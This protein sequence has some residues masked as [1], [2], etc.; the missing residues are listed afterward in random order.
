MA[1]QTP[2]RSTPLR[3][4]LVNSRLKAASQAHR[5][6]TEVYTYP[7]RLKVNIEEGSYYDGGRDQNGDPFVSGEL[8][9]NNEGYNNPAVLVRIYAILNSNRK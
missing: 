5:R 6:V 1:T 2:T 4:S 8:E 3:K 9:I 7:K